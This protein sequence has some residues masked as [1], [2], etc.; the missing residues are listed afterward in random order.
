MGP[1]AQGF[2]PEPDA[3]DMIQR[4]LLNTDFLLFP[5]KNRTSTP[6]IT[7][8]SVMAMGLQWID[9][10]KDT[11]VAVVILKLRTGLARNQ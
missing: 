10:Q 1:I 4:R 5:E 7:K 9:A 6:T 8:G 2:G 11:A 3:S